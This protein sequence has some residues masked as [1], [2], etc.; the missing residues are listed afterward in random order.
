MGLSVTAQILSF[1]GWKDATSIP[2]MSIYFLWC[3][4]VICAGPISNAIL[5]TPFVTPR[6]F[7]PQY[8]QTKQVAYCK[9]ERARRG[10]PWLV[11][12]AYF[13]LI[14]GGC[15]GWNIER[16]HFSIQVCLC[17]FFFEG[18]AG[19]FCT[20]STAQFCLE[21]CWFGMHCLLCCWWFI[22]TCLLAF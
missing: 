13:V 19:S 9:K 15:R 16:S 14:T 4:K 8:D 22:K 10:W 1:F 21:M 12:L 7:L 18:L 6:G 5:W 11:W 20:E 3:L 2:L 17:F